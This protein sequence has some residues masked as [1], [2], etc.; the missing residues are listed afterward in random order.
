M[1]CS[2]GAAAVF[3]P[4]TTTW[5]ADLGK[6]VAAEQVGKAIE[7]LQGFFKS[8]SSP[9]RKT[10]RD[11]V[12]TILSK[13]ADFWYDSWS[14]QAPPVLMVSVRSTEKGDPMADHLV[15]CVNNG[16]QAVVFE[17]WAW[18][19][20]SM[21]VHDLTDA[22]DGDDLAAYQSLCLMTLIPCGTRPK[23]G[24][25]PGGTVSWMSYA[26]R[27]G[28]VEIAK[29]AEPDGTMSAIVTVSGIMDAQKA[30]S[31]RKYTLPGTV[32]ETSA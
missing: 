4:A 24:N 26:A 32:A 29:V 28:T 1:G 31:K 13:D 15:A 25:S 17:P 6:A 14:H 7:G 2:S 27:N 23:T 8:W 16:R 5:L 12:S 19:A 22:K 21:Y 18:Q 20:L 3:N 11:S 30:P 10:V 9:A